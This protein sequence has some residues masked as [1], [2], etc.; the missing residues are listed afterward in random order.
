MKLIVGLGNPGPKYA[1]TRHNFGFDV[2]DVLAIRWDIS[3]GTE[4][5]HG[6][7]G[8]G[9]IAEKPVALFKPTTYM[10]RSG[11][12]VQA[13]GRFYKLE[14]P[15]LLVISDDL[16]L[17]TGRLRMRANGSA[18]GHNGLQDIVDRV[19][20][21]AW[22]RLRLGI[23]AAVGDPANFV[24]ARFCENERTLVQNV[25]ERAAD[26]VECWVVEGVDV[27]MTRFNGADK[28]EP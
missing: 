10:N 2:V 14:F 8:T 25:R 11:Q 1:G 6:W 28:G 9:T 26:A 21:D 13:A 27:A 4:K 20:G 24:L 17:P 5:F 23:G 15:D 16:A 12:A 22:S 19:G 3:M 7:L 18:G